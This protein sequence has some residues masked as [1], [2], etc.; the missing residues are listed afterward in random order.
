MD[1][2]MLAI[3]LQQEWIFREVGHQAQFNLRIIRGKQN[4]AVHGYEGG[5]NLASQFGANVNVLQIWIDRRE[6]TGGSANG[7]ECG[8]HAMLSVRKQRQAVGVIRFQ[9]GQLAIF[10]YQTRRFMMLSQL[11]QNVLRGGDDLTA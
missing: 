8:V 5:A 4:I 6:A 9:F 3:G 11:L 10:E 1:I 7:I 2:D